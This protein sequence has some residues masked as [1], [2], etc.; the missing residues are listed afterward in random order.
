[1][2]ESF[3]IKSL[4]SMYVRRL[5]FMMF[6]L[7]FFFY[8]SDLSAKSRSHT[9]P[10]MQALEEAKSYVP[11]EIYIISPVLAP[12]IP[13]RNREGKELILDNFY[14]QVVVLS[15]WASWCTPCL[16]MMGS[17]SE[18]QKKYRRKPL[19]VIALS[20]DFK[21]IASL[22]SLFTQNKWNLPIYH[23]VKNRFFHAFGT[24]S[25]PATY[26]IDSEN[27]II[28]TAVNLV[29][30]QQEGVDLLLD[31]LLSRMA[32]SQQVI[33][34][35]SLDQKKEQKDQA[36][37]SPSSL[38]KEPVIPSDALTVIPN[39][40]NSD[41]DIKGQAKP[42]DPSV[43]NRKTPERQPVPKMSDDPVLKQKYQIIN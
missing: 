4:R 40:L 32:P 20:Q 22:D 1:M 42:I 6:L 8:Y 37:T 39:K 9:D 36:K 29:N 23:D 18:L 2:F 19:R 33:E 7:S 28:A 5:Y 13:F 14:G 31:T 12:E 41:A 3:D 35:P 30:F 24:V 34:Y 43:N 27:Q 21:D 11:E 26:I 10:Y 25:L 17:L 15:L 38:I 16:Q